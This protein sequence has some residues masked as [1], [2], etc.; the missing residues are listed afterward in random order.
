MRLA[1]LACRNCSSRTARRRSGLTARAVMSVSWVGCGR[2]LDGRRKAR[3]PHREN[4]LLA[5]E[6]SSVCVRPF[7]RHRE[8]VAP[9]HGCG[10][11]A[12]SDIELVQ[13]VRDVDAGG[14]DADEQLGGNPCVAVT[15]GDEA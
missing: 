5:L 9:G 12:R 4:A 7:T 1:V 2:Y 10:F 14:L 8:A 11:A 3:G 13:D 6:Q 15:R